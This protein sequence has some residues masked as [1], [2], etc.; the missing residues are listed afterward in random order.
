MPNNKSAKSNNESELQLESEIDGEE[1]NESSKKSKSRSPRQSLMGE[2][3]MAGS[4][5]DLH[6][7]DTIE[8]DMEGINDNIEMLMLS[9]EQ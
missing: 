7:L 1:Y 8:K 4:S 3:S 5:H 6:L 9:R 2:S